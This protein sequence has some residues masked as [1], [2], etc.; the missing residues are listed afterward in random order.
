MKTILLSLII[1]TI[2][3]GIPEGVYSADKVTD[4]ND[5]IRDCTLALEMA[6][7]E[8]TENVIKGTKPLPSHEQQNKAI[9]CMYYVIGFKDALYVNQI[10]QE[11]NDAKSAICLP[12]NNFNNELAVRVVLKYLKDN[13]K[14]L[15]QP[16]SALMFNAFYYAFPCGK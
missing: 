6:Q 14:L 8:Y 5:V 12:Y 13:P 9:Q 7:D 1:A 2:Y 15:S 3:M 4:G 16:Q 10:Y 11:K